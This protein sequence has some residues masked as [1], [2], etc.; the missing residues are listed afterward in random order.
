MRLRGCLRVFSQSLRY[1]ELRN[2]LRNLVAAP[3][4]HDTREAGNSS[5]ICGLL[6]VFG[7][8][9]VNQF[10]NLFVMSIS[11]CSPSDSMSMLSIHL[12]GI[13]QFV[14]RNI[15]FPKKAQ[16]FFVL[17]TIRLGRSF[18]TRIQGML[19]PQ[20]GRDR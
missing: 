18:Q 8:T 5:R 11:D 12:N 6:L 2:L 3:T 19:L 20:G 14:Y 4:S 13:F 17:C 9:P 10:K 16:V 15:I 7:T 1:V